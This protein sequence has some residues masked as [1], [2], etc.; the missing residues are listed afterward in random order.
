LEIKRLE[1]H[2]GDQQI[3]PLVNQMSQADIEISRLPGLSWLLEVPWLWRRPAR[4]NR[5]PVT[6]IRE[7]SPYLRRD[8]GALD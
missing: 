8:L 6:D 1:A 5:K 4:S 7:L 3:K 2:I